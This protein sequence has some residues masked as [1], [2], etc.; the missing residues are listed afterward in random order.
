MPTILFVRLG[1]LGYKGFVGHYDENIYLGIK[2][3]WICEIKQIY[4]D[5]DEI[6]TILQNIQTIPVE[7]ILIENNKQNSTRLTP[8]SINALQA[9]G[10]LQCFT[11]PN[12]RRFYMPM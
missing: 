6:C 3:A 11:L 12:A 8:A 9:V 5:L 4:F 7:T 1:D 2:Q 10:H